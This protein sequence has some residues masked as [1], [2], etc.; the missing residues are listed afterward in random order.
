MYRLY[1]WSYIL[2]AIHR[3]IEY[4]LATVTALCLYKIIMLI[5]PS[6][7][8]SDEKD[9]KWSANMTAE[10]TI[11]FTNMLTAT[12]PSIFQQRQTDRE[13]VSD[14]ATNE[15]CSKNDK[16]RPLAPSFSQDLLVVSSRAPIT[17]H[18]NQ[19]SPHEW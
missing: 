10:C 11:A 17:L 7:V 3:W 18:F 6:E 13:W 9:G 15:G 2:Y 8:G 5:V 16:W 19:T 1:M 4:E 14:F 12:Q